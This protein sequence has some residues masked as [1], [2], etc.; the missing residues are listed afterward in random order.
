MST[1]Y[2]RANTPQL[3]PEQRLALEAGFKRVS[4]YCYTDALLHEFVKSG[5]VVFQGEV[6]STGMNQMSTGS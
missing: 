5:R 1:F 6:G 4:N 3:T 2:G